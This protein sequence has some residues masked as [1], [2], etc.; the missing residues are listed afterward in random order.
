MGFELFCSTL[1]ALLFGTF[2]C[3]AGYRFFIVLLP[4]WGLFFGLFLGAQTVQA[5]LG[6]AFFATV[7]SWVAGFVV[8]VIFAVL[9]YLF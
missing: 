4:V 8:G 5:L 7:T 1:L 2:V 6:E 3:F 9:S